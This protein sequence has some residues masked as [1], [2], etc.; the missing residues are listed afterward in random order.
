M[1]S[2][3]NFEMTDH[4]TDYSNEN[5]RDRGSRRDFL[6]TTGAGIAVASVAGCLG[7]AETAVAD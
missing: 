1:K 5:K 2:N 7:G 3:D 6:R 4:G